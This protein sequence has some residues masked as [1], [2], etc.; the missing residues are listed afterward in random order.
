MDVPLAVESIQELDFVLQCATLAAAVGS[1]VALRA[2]R[3]N[4]RRDMAEIVARWTGFALGLAVA[5]Q[6]IDALR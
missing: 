1:V 4:P 3:R 5:V 6:L 2:R